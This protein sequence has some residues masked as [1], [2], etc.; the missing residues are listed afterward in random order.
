MKKVGFILF[1]LVL[2]LCLMIPAA[3]PVSADTSY[4]V[5][6]RAWEDL[7]PPYP[8]FPPSLIVPVEWSTTSPAAGGVTNTQF[9]V[10][11]YDGGEVTLAAP[12]TDN[13]G[14]KFYV[15]NTWGIGMPPAGADINTTNRTV[16][17]IPDGNKIATARYHRISELD[18]IYPLRPDVN[19]VGIEHTVWVNISMPVAGVKIMFNIDGANSGASGYAYTDSMG[20]ASYTYT[21]L[22]PGTDVIWAYI[23]SNS[24]GQFDYIDINGDGDFDEGEPRE[25]RTINNTNKSWINN[26]LTGGG[27]YKDSNNVVWEFQFVEKLEVL[28]EGGATGHFRIIHDDGTEVVIYD[29]D[30]IEMLY[31]MGGPTSS[32]PAAKNIVR[33]RGTGTGSDG[34]DVMLLVV[35]EDVDKGKDKIAIVEVTG[36]PPPAPPVIIPWIGDITTTPPLNPPTFVTISGG[37]FQVHDVKSPFPV[38]ESDPGRIILI[39]QTDPDD[40]NGDYVFPVFMS[41]GALVG[42]PV[43]M[44]IVDDFQVDSGYILT[45]GIYTIIELPVA[46]WSLASI[47]IDD[48]SGDSYICGPKAFINLSPGET[49]I[50]TYYNTMNP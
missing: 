37:S 5:V 36:P 6:V 23:D 42:Y 32:P 25:P 20:T 27:N 11:V 17:F 12:L 16:T 28:P 44:Q 39:K 26:F 21:G 18:S 43:G 22:N 15:F 8:P 9:N 40:P 34:S 47:D 35:I 29:I 48:P 49:V 41:Y 45:P 1:S 33:F 2:C 38:Q 50:V 10:P 14:L 19:P 7:P 31:F 30:K 3:L 24:N 4:T 13:E 46:G